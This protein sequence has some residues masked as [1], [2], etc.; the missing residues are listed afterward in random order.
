MP[1]VEKN[2]ILYDEEML[3]I[4]YYAF[5][6]RVQQPLYKKDYVVYRSLVLQKELGDWRSAPDFSDTREQLWWRESVEV[7]YKHSGLPS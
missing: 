3:F 5:C 6:S 2:V 7:V 1:V 4:S